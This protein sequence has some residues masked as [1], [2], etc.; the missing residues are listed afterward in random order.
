MLPTAMVGI[1]TTLRIMSAKG[2]CHMRPYTG[3]W[4]ATVWPVETLRMATPASLNALAAA[5]RSP[6]S[7][8]P[9]AQ[10]LRGNSHRERLLAPA[11]RARTASQHLQRK[12]QAIRDRAAVVV[13]CAGW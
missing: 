1:P 8:P 5:M 7:S 4:S 10:S 11:T 13:A 12:S 3:R 6:S 2:V 9:G